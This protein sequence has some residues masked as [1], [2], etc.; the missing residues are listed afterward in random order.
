MNCA[1]IKELSVTMRCPALSRLPCFLLLPSSAM[2]CGNHDCV[3]SG[4]EQSI[5]F[6]TY[7]TQFFVPTA[8]GNILGGNS[9]V[10][11]LGH[12]QVVGGKS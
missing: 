3:V 8:L 5:S 11:A 1:P 10:A 2:V 9:L 6:G 12:A 7:L 4:R